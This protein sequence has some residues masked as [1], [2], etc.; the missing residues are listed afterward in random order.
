MRLDEQ[1][2]PAVL[3]ALDEPHVPERAATVERDLGEVGDELPELAGPARRRQPQTVQ[4][5]V[6]LE[7]GIR[8]E[9]GQVEPEGHLLDLHREFGHS[10]ETLHQ[11]LTEACEPPVRY[12]CGVDDAEGADVHR[13]AGPLAVEEPGVRSAQPS[14]D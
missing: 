13:P 14:H 9:H 6:E 5:V 10:R 4:V 8:H 3:E 11:E 1:C 12:V 2:G 7:I